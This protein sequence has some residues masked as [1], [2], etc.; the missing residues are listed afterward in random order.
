MQR[1]SSQPHVWHLPESQR[2]LHSC[3]L[4]KGNKSRVALPSQPNLSFSS[5]FSAT[6]TG[7]NT[8]SVFLP[9]CYT[10]TFVMS[11]YTHKTLFSF[12]L[13]E[14]L[15]WLLGGSYVYS[16]KASCRQSQ[17]CP[18]AECSVGTGSELW[19]PPACSP[20]G[21]ASFIWCSLHWPF[22]YWTHETGS[23]KQKQQLEIQTFNWWSSR[24][25]VSN[26]ILQ[27]DSFVEQKDPV[28]SFSWFPNIGFPLFA[29]LLSLLPPV[30]RVGTV[31]E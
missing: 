26:V 4:E 29:W 28:C 22:F 15:V 2:C 27:F 19:S 23:I 17:L 6:V 11:S 8:P 20:A 12:T 14:G 5:S 10:I 1:A 7:S 31:M 25:S 16:P 13:W 30:I 21:P 3:W 24:E 18:A 9:S